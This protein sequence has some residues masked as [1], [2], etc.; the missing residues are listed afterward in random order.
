MNVLLVLIILG[1]YFARR[2]IGPVK[3]YWFCITG[4]IV[5]KPRGLPEAR[6]VLT[7][8]DA[9]APPDCVCPVARSPQAAP[10]HGTYCT[11]LGSE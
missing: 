1:V 2:P 8:T 3:W 4:S 5:G 7:V 10:I 9:P 11:L 6:I